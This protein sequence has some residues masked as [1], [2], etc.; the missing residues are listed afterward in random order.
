MDKRARAPRFQERL[1]QALDVSGLSQSHLA[2]EIGVDRSTVSQLLRGQAPRLPNGQVVAEL[3]FALGVSADWLLG[4]SDRPK[5][6]AQVLATA[7]DMPEASRAAVDEVLHGWHIEARGYKIRHVPA[8]LPDILKTP[9]LIRW[10]YATTLQ[11]NPEAAISSAEDRLALLRDSGCDY[12]IAIPQFEVASFVAQEGYYKHLPTAL[13]DAQLA[14]FADLH[15]LLYP[16]I[17]VFLFDARSVFSAPITVFGPLL[18]VVYL[19]RNY[20]VFRDTERVSALI[21]QFDWLIRSA[22]V[23]AH[24][25]PA[26]LRALHSG[27]K[28]VEPL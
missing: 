27:C 19:G 7:L 28:A 21:G 22:Q 3:A 24:E 10:E 14:W 8:T 5:P 25:W 26:H 4:L 1:R 2:R 9:D 6:A 18:G 17:R 12:E 15:A 13:R 16:T 20:M 23:S 11:S